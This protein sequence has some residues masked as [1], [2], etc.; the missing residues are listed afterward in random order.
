MYP[1]R[2]YASPAGSRGRCPPPA[3]AF[4]SGVLVGYVHRDASRDPRCP[5]T[6]AIYQ[7][8]I[9]LIDG[10]SRAAAA[11]S[12]PGGVEQTHRKDPSGSRSNRVN[13][14][15]DTGVLVPAGGGQGQAAVTGAPMLLP[16]L[17]AVTSPGLAVA[18]R[19]RAGSGPAGGGRPSAGP[20]RP[21]AAGQP[22]GLG[23]RAAEQEVENG[24]AQPGSSSTRSL[25]TELGLTDA[26]P[27]PE[28]VSIA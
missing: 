24:G 22:P 13:T 14:K 8:D 12:R 11:R 7:S 23:E 9:I 19:W 16:R 15:Q 1:W 18:G 6:P 5:A 25:R 10:R 20:H 2:D 4:R 3:Q 21:G 28:T 27:R 17:Q 26:W